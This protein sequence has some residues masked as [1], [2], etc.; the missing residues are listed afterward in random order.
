MRRFSI[1]IPTRERVDTLMS[2]LQTALAIRDEG[3]EIVVSDNFSQDGTGDAVAQVRDSRVKYV[4]TGKR[5]SMSG[6]WEFGLSHA[7]GDWVNITGDDD[8]FLPSCLEKVN[9]IIDRTGVEAVNSA[10]CRYY[11]PSKTATQRAELGVPIAHS[12]E[13]RDSRGFLE[14]V[15]KG[16]R[17]YGE[18]P[19]LYTGA[20]VSRRA[21]DRARHPDG[22]F[23][24]SSIPDAYSAVTLA[25]A[26]DRYAYSFE[27]IAIAGLSKHS[28]G[29]SL[30]GQPSGQTGNGSPIQKFLEED[31]IPF[32]PSIPR[33]KNGS[34]LKC[35]LAFI[36]EAYLQSRA[37]FPNSHEV[38]P[39]DQLATILARAKVEKDIL[40][41]WCQSFASLHYLDLEKIRQKAR[42][43]LLKLKMTGIGRRIRSLYSHFDVKSPDYPIEDVNAAVQV[44][45]S[46]LKKRPS[47]LRRIVA[48]QS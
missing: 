35:E 4:N 22:Q 27:P 21:I 23:F 42:K 8:G 24:L 17:S 25:Q 36:F 18:L 9:Q 15:L 20:F 16:E 46:I 7:T 5:I 14:K 44:A 2:T 40:D 41:E 39:E 1:I 31:N 48:K 12:F 37:I 47:I 33:L 11:W 38:S 19:W 45:V 26:T 6:N 10:C 32:H 13:V 43:H 29:T 28:T 3:L 30:F 34:F